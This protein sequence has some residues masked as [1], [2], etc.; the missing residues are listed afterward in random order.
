MLVKNRFLRYVS[1]C[2]SSNRESTT[3]P[4]SYR[5]FD[6]AHMLAFELRGMGVSDVRVDNSGIVYAKI[7]ATLGYEKK[8]PIAFLA[9]LDTFPDICGENVN[10]QIIENYNGEDVTL[11]TSGLVLSS[12]DFLHLSKLKGETLITTDGTTLLGADDK[13]GIAEIM[14]AIDYILIHKVPHGAISIA[15]V[16]DEEIGHGSDHFDVKNFGAERAYAI[17]GGAAGEVIYENFNAAQV[18]V[19]VTGKI[20]HTGSAKHQMVNAQLIGMEIFQML[21]PKEIPA[22]TENREG[23]YHLLSSHGDVGEAVYIYEIRDHDE[24]L[25]RERIGMFTKI[26]EQMNMKYGEGT[27]AVSVMEKYRNMQTKIESCP[28]MIAAAVEANRLA[29][30]S[31]NIIPV[32]GGLIGSRLSFKGILCPSLGSSGYAYHSVMEHITVQSME[33]VTNIIIELV[34]QY[35]E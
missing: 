2:T 27:V 3:V 14:T 31:P 28:D 25:F 30:V 19:H 11:G 23:C 1:V 4:S 6:L 13:A 5:Q 34:K 29:G 16:S 26:Q 18:E 10:P 33:K 24:T 15:F 9:H 12:S 35:A 21:P 20:G 32:R 8:T 17:D 22:L 7:P